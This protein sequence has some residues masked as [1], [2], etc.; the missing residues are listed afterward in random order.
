LHKKP[1]VAER[2]A[3][4]TSLSSLQQKMKDKLSGARFRWINEQLYTTESTKAFESFQD[5]PSLF[6]VVS[7]NSIFFL[8]FFSFL[9]SMFV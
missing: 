7:G 3:A 5:D 1:K 8:F 2:E 4:P 6:D 9:S